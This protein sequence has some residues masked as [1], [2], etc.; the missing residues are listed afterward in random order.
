MPRLLR[1]LLF[2]VLTAL[3]VPAQAQLPNVDITLVDNG[4]NEL[5]VRVRPDADFDGLFSSLVFTI[6]WNAS[7]GT[8]LGNISQVMPALAYMPIG[9]S[10]GQIDAGSFRYQ[11]FAGFGFTPLNSISESW[12]AGTEYALMTIPVLNGSDLFEIVNDT[13]T[14]DIANNGDYYISLNGSDQTGMIYSISTGVEMG[15]P[16]LEA[17]HVQPNPA[18]DRVVVNFLADPDVEQVVEVVDATGR[19]ILRQVV[20]R[21]HGEARMELDLRTVQ[22]GAYHVVLRGGQ[23]VITRKL[24]VQ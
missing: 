5:E 16:D 2:A 19:S 24:V 9:K 14:G 23:R 3:L 22:A 10:G 15:D 6:R 8:D 13:W 7:T 17:F 1:S 21:A 18:S 20:A 4:N 11:V 12:T